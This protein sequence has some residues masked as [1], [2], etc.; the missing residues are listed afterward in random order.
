MNKFKLGIIQPRLSYY[1][2]GGEKTTY[3]HAKLLPS[4][5]FEVY[6][7][8]LKPLDKRSFVYDDLLKN[9]P[10]NLHIKE[11]EVSEKFKYIYEM[12]VGE[13]R[14]RWDIESL[15]FSE[16]IYKDLEKDKLNAILNYYILD[17]LFKPRNIKNILYLLGYSS[18]HS[19]YWKSFFGFYDLTISIGT[20]VREKW[21][22]YLNPANSTSILSTGVVYPDNEIFKFDKKFLNLVFAGRLIERK[23]ILT[24]LSAI[25]KIKDKIPNIKLHILGDGPLKEKITTEIE[26]LKIGD[27]VELHGLVENPQA[28]FKSADICVFPSHE[29]EGLL[30]VVMEAMICGKP[31]ITTKDNG[32]EGIIVNNKTGILVEPK[33]IEEL[34]LEIER[35]AQ[36]ENLRNKMGKAAKKFAEEN[37]LWEKHIEKLKSL[38]VNN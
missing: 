4:E 6:L 13:D 11:F 3:F 29:K 25:E 35:L 15:F 27:N 9:K 23:G 24:L 10:E 1:V 19:E 16:L 38:I 12:P 7:Y 30:G 33:N 31:V 20:N 32:N 21:S 17:G 8:T 5:N 2:G 28:Y 22:Q 36:D 34:S 37:L 26:T 14:S 18:N